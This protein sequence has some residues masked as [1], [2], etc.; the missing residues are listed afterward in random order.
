VRTPEY[1][2]ARAALARRMREKE[3]KTAAEV[4]AVLKAMDAKAKERKDGKR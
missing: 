2:Y 4:R 1:Q 3:G